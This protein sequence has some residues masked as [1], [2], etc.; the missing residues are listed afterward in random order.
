MIQRIDLIYGSPSQAPPG[1]RMLIIANQGVFM[2]GMMVQEDN[3][4]FQFAWNAVGRLGQ[5][6][7]AT[8][9]TLCSWTRARWSQNSDCL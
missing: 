4:N 7:A 2:N 6:R 5:G 8:A 1:E 3:D 9:N